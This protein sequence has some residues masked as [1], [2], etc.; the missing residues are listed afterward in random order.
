MFYLQVDRWWVSETGLLYD[1]EWMIVNEHG[2]LLT[3]KREPR[4]V[5]I[6]P[7]IDLE[8][9]GLILQCEGNLKNSNLRQRE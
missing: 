6:K 2:M 1:R 9:N 3:Q 8:Q 4:L 7:S 5:F